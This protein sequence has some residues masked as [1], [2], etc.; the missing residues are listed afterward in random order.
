MKASR[1]TGA[2][3][4]L[5][6]LAGGALRCG[7]LW[8][9]AAAPEFRYP[10]IDAA[11][12]LSWARGLAFG[13]WR[14]PAGYADPLIRERPFFRPPGYPYFLAAALAAGGGDLLA[15]RIAQGLLGLLAA[16]LAYRLGRRW[17]SSA[18]GV[19]WCAF[20]CCYPLLVFF[21]MELLG[22]SLTVPLT[23]VWLGLWARLRTRAGV[24]P[25]LAAGIWSGLFLLFRPNLVPVLAAA[26]VWAW[27]VQAP[28]PRRRRAATLAGVAL[29]AAVA[30]A[31]SALRNR[32]VSGETVLISANAGM[33]LAIGNNEVTDGTDHYLPGYG[34]FGSPFDYPAA[35]EELGR[36]LG[37]EP[38][39][40]EASRRWTRRALAFV[41]ENPGAFLELTLRKAALFWG[42]AEVTNNRDLEAALASS[43]VLSSVPL[44][45]SPLL[46]LAL[47]GAVFS[48]RRLRGGGNEGRRRRQVAALLALFVLFYFLSILPAAAAA[49]YRVPV[50]PVLAF[51][52]AAGLAELARALRER[53]WR[54]AAGYAALGA[55]LYAVACLSP[56]E[57]ESSGAKFHFDRAVALEAARD[58]PAALGEYR[59]AVLL[60]PGHVRARNNLGALL[61]KQGD[62]E[63][64]LE[65][66][67]AALA[68]EPEDARTWNNLGEALLAAG[69]RV[70][71]EEALQRALVL[72][73]RSLKA[74]NNLGI[75]EEKSGRPREAEARY[76]E[77]LALDGS[78]ARAHYNL[79]N[80]LAKEGRRGEALAH[81]RAAVAAAP[82][83]AEAWNNLG[84]L[85]VRSGAAREAEEAYGRALESAAPPPGARVNLA[86]LRAAAGDY[87]AAESL[88]LQALERDPGDA[89]ASY[90]YAYTL[91][92]AGRRAE[93]LRQYRAVLEIDPGREAAREG[94]ERTSA[95]G[96]E[97]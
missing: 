24:V 74:L 48:R 67:R 22:V 50:L 30:I 36:T 18:V 41:R 79:A 78:Y 3:L 33:S 45:F 75:C 12:H 68:E 20:L 92:L 19:V 28:F 81:Y 46:A 56:V 93:A 86:N 52:A 85:L 4:L 96:G 55:G 44:S 82:D 9:Y 34:W 91:E 71:A 16:F 72:D 60:D 88:Y 8:E 90:N 73:P 59:S 77:A 54:F 40:S 25:G 11:Y 15:P 38:G 26:A 29:G 13:A 14:A 47:A 70:R 17:W 35:V 21:E 76:R 23:L 6:L 84:N 7:Y 31:P 1:R 61:L 51:F 57:Y 39:Y 5:S 89:E 53:R 2:F 37:R 63:A 62:I 42:P 49:R 65:Q 94:L 58:L 69:R 10:A 87:A 80:L 83:F 64:A 95:G 32:M 97:R 43:R 27:L 66:Y